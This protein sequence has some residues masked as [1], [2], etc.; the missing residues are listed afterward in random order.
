MVG[1]FEMCITIVCFIPTWDDRWFDNH[2]FLTTKQFMKHKYQ[3]AQMSTSAW[4][5]MSQVEEDIL[6]RRVLTSFDAQSNF[7]A[8][9]GSWITLKDF[10]VLF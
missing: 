6:E 10:F 4:C 1:G 5:K 3:K 2:I 9:S 8:K 7:F